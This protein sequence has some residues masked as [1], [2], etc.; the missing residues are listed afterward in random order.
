MQQNPTSS[1]ATT[2]ICGQSVSPSS[3]ALFLALTFWAAYRYVTWDQLSNCQHPGFPSRSRGQTTS[4]GIASEQS[5]VDCGLTLPLS[6]GSASQLRLST[7]P[8][9]KH[10]AVPE[11]WNSCQSESRDQLFSSRPSL[12]ADGDPL[13]SCVKVAPAACCASGAFAAAQ[14]LPVSIGRPRNLPHQI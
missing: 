7:H 13:S 1:S 10:L 12:Q 11:L 9:S 14:Q 3:S 8:K 4:N 5:D 6:L 2:C